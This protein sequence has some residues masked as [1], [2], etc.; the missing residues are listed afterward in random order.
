MLIQKVKFTLEWAMK[1]QGGWSTP[2]L[3]NFTSR[4]DTLYSLYRRL[5]GPQGQ[6]NA[7]AECV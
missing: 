7:Y 1:A 2:H 4:K 6:S 5:G 3:G